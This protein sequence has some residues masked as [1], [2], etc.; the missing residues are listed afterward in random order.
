LEC[1][2]GGARRRFSSASGMH[3]GPENQAAQNR[4]IEL[5]K[6]QWTWYGPEDATWEHEEAMQ[7]E[8]HIFLNIFENL[9]VICKYDALRTMHK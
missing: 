8:Y 1:D 5:V 4:S 3:S 2:S 7:A 9:V 6:V